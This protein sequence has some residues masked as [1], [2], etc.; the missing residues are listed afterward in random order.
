MEGSRKFESRRKWQKEAEN[1]RR[2]KE[3][4]GKKRQKAESSRS[5][6]KADDRK[7][8]LCK[9]PLIRDRFNPICYRVRQSAQRP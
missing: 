1:T 7:Q 6:K 2:K 8:S 3:E 5:R 9:V 4:K